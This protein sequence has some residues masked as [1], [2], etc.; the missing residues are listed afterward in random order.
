LEEAHPLEELCSPGIHV[1]DGEDVEGRRKVWGRR[2]PGRFPAG[3]AEDGE[4]V[5]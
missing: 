2:K 3:R 4:K 5:R 1:L